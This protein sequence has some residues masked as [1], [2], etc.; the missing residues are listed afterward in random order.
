MK[1]NKKRQGKGKKYIK[2]K[3]ISNFRGS[4]G[5]GGTLKNI[6]KSIKLQP[7]VN[8]LNKMSKYALLAARQ[9][10]KRLGG[11]KR[12]KIPRIIQVPRRGGFLMPLLAGISALG[13]LSG[14]ISQIVKAVNET[15]AAQKQLEE[16]K[17]HNKTIE[18]V[19]L[20]SSKTK[21]GAGIYLKPYRRG[22]GLF[23]HQKNKKNQSRRKKKHQI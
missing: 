17:R 20:G 14:G 9:R 21:K 11:S 12:I 5:G 8:D 19:M 4:G 23:I 16:A 18:S 10:I 6:M 2:K 15:K 1:T 22:L 7:N 13:G 3:K